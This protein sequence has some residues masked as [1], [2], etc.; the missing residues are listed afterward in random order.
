MSQN[1]Q[2]DLGKA[3]KSG[4]HPRGFASIGPGWGLRIPM[5]YRLPRLQAAAAGLG[6]TLG[7]LMQSII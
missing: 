7:E 3:Q 4:A 6:T 5:F 1:Q 2:E